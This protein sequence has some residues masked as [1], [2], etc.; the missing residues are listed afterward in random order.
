M[1]DHCLVKKRSWYMMKYCDFSESVGLEVLY[2][3]ADNLLE[4]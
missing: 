1:R 4:I 2:V 3:L